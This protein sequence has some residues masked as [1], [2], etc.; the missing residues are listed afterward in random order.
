MR[1]IVLIGIIILVIG[2]L[3]GGVF[4]LLNYNSAPRVLTRASIALRNGLY[5]DA[6]GQAE[7]YISKRPNEMEGYFIKGRAANRLGRFTE[8]REAL[9]KAKELDPEHV[10]IQLEMASSYSLQAQPLT[11]MAVRMPTAAQYTEGISLLQQANG[12]IRDISTDDPEEQLDVQ[13]ALG[14]NLADI[15]RMNELLARLIDQ[16]VARIVSATEAAE[17]KRREAEAVRAQAAA[18]AKQAIDILTAILR[19]DNQRAAAAST[20]VEL[21]LDRQDTQALAEARKL[22][23]DQQ[24]PPALAAALLMREDLRLSFNEPTE[25]TRQQRVEQIAQQLDQVLEQHPNHARTRLARAEVAMLQNDWELARKMISSVIEQDPSLQ[26]A[27]LLWGQVLL[28][29]KDYVA[30]EEA[31]RTLT[32]ESR[33]YAPVHYYYALAARGAGYQGV[34]SESMRRAI[35]IQPDYIEPRVFLV[36]RLLET[37]RAG[38]AFTEAEQAYRINKD[39]PRVVN[40]YVKSAIASNR[41]E[42]A[43]EVLQQLR[44]QPQ[45]N[46]DMLRVMAH[47]Y[48][49]LGDE[50]GNAAALQTLAERDPSSLNG[51]LAKA[52][53]HNLAGDVNEA[54]AAL[55][56]ACRKFPLEAEPRTY[57]ARIYSGQ[58][59]IMQ[60]MEMLNEALRLDQDNVENRLMLARLYFRNG[61][62][63]EC[64]NACQELLRRMPDN[65]EATILANQV[66]IMLNQPIDIAAIEAGPAEGHMGV[67]LAQAY[68][69]ADQPEKA[70]EVALAELKKNPTEVN[71]RQLLALAYFQMGQHDKCAKEWQQLLKENPDDLSKYMQ[72]LLANSQQHGFEQAAVKLQ[73]AEGAKPEL[74]SLCLGWYH[75]ERG[76]HGEA[77]RHYTAAI[78]TPGVDEDLTNRAILWR[79]RAFNALGD[80]GRA[81]ADLR[82]LAQ[83]PLWQKG[84]KLAMAQVLH[85][86]RRTDQALKVLAELTD[87]VVADND[88]PLLRGMAEFYTQIGHA[89]KALELCDRVESQSKADLNVLL[90]KGAVLTAARRSDESIALYRRARD[91]QP[92]NQQTWQLLALALDAANKPDEARQV[93]L[94]MQNL[95]ESAAAV[96]TLEL[97]RLY[98]RRGLQT[99]AISEYKRLI[100]AGHK[101]PQLHL[102]AG[103]SLALLGQKEEARRQLKQVPTHSRQY[104]LAQ[105][106]LADLA[107]SP[108]EKLRLLDQLDE[109][110]PG[111]P[112]VLAQQI[113]A[114]FELN[115]GDQAVKRL[116]AYL[117]DG[118]R[119]LPN[120]VARMVVQRLLEADN[121]QAATNVALDM[122][123]RTALPDWRRLSICLLGDADADRAA[124]LLPPP[125]KAEVLDCMLALWLKGRQPQEARK[126]AERL[127]VLQ[128]IDNR[129]GLHDQLLV[130][131][132][133]GEQDRASRLANLANQ[134]PFVS[135]PLRE[136]YERSVTD[137]PGEAA[138]LLGAR[139]AR[140]MYLQPLDAKRAMAVL[141]SRPGALL[142]AELIVGGSS[143]MALV[144]R[145]LSTVQP[146]ESMVARR[147]Q[148]VVLEAEGK[149]QQAAQL[150]AQVAQENDNHTLLLYQQGKTLEKAGLHDEAIAVYRRIVSQ[151]ASA[152]HAAN[153]AAYL[154][155]LRQ[156]S[157]ADELVEARRMIDSAIAAMV[158]SQPQTSSRAAQ[159]AP[160]L[161]DTRGWISFLQGDSSQA[162]IDLRRAV[163]GLPENANVHAHV[164]MAEAK[165]GCPMMARM[166]VQAALDLASKAAEQKDGTADEADLNH[167]VDLA[168]Q[169][170]VLLEA[171]D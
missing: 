42:A 166:H 39:D 83:K 14:L 96:A 18:A 132:V 15:S 7:I 65:S 116:N 34:A 8:A 21:C 62:L 127:S 35:E 70:V 167:A 81:L 28:N 56:E 22:I 2:L 68:L 6:L 160:A 143:D 29:Q 9:A 168:R 36:N 114:L 64:G 91:M 4:L 121:Q 106:M 145:A 162:L 135:E 67:A 107:A 118:R 61:M 146:G 100:A 71:A 54:I 103:Q 80:Q 84:A 38:M 95:G 53:A 17:A 60:A 117:D 133:S 48:G 63:P 41:P 138:N 169:A 94:D 45:L 110:R 165:A 20:L 101:D 46:A 141:R 104:N 27:R 156:Q 11:L 147:M 13:Q 76:H 154:M 52:L 30:A 119:G 58:N 157:N 151:D 1:R 49:L 98:S 10:G 122:T 131:I 16:E 158:Q 125:E 25:A 72:L 111:Q 69:A 171:D 115:R 66:R 170:L 59:R 155:T 140:L 108:E 139:L 99:A 164:A 113:N 159:D 82:Q 24:R 150:L 74:V 31:L 75:T 79:A 142:A 130:A 77:A 93:L 163:R 89:D 136:L 51:H 87:A 37:D 44:D 26:E 128:A 88:R 33:G 23:M 12:V 97:G 92:G 85:A 102:V 134:P 57:L 149:Q 120:E 161:L 55:Q 50:D 43:R 73:Q 90:L 129:L 109:H 148:A 144:R 126:W 152:I 3:G 124:E 78:N 40:I 137:G 153:D 32:T 112:R 86:S 5:A 105:Q 123:K 47:G 19:H